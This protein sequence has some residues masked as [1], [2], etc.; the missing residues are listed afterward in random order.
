M[1]T[2]IKRKG[3]RFSADGMD[4]GQKIKRGR[5]LG[6]R[7]KG[8]DRTGRKKSVESGD[9][10]QLEWKRIPPYIINYGTML[11]LSSLPLLQYESEE[12]NYSLYIG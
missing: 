1:F 9:S 11:Y 10:R 8:P 6:I 12:R 4:S 2:L 3:C 7:W 5:G